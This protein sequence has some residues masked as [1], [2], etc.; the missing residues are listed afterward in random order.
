M[1]TKLLDQRWRQSQRCRVA[2]HR[3]Y[4]GA[5][6]NVGSMTSQAALAMGFAGTA[7]APSL[8]GFPT[9]VT[10][11]FTASGSLFIA[12]TAHLITGK[13]DRVAT[14]PQ[15]VN[16]RKRHGVV[17][18]SGQI[19]FRPVAGTS[20]RAGNCHDIDVWSCGVARSAYKRRRNRRA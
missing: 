1:P 16:R 14:V 19:R 2:R 12:D 3:W 11:P 8:T 13:R 5:V 17:R 6:Y 18:R 9:L 7:I 10:V 20:S 15:P 4:N